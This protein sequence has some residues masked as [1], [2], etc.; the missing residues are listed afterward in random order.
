[1]D[2][3]NFNVRFPIRRAVAIDCTNSGNERATMG[4]LPHRSNGYCLGQTDG[5]GRASLGLALIPSHLL[6]ACKKVRLM[7]F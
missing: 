5:Q 7:T 2:V 3:A 6:P 4:A 1:M